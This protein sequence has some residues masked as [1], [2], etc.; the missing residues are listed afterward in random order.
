M[1]NFIPSGTI[2]EHLLGEEL[3]TA[4]A[5]GTATVNTANDTFFTDFF[6]VFFSG[7]TTAIFGL[8]FDIPPGGITTT[9]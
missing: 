6:V 8:A 5:P 7:F 2:D 1:R 3:S 9:P 4:E